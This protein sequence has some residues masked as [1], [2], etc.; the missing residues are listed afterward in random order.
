MTVVPIGQAEEIQV[1]DA[2]GEHTHK[3]CSMTAMLKIPPNPSLSMY[4]T[5]KLAYLPDSK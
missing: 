5:E 3:G 4:I 1:R 2:A